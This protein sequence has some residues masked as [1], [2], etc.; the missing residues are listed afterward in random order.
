MLTWLKSSSSEQALV[1][2]TR[3]CTRRMLLSFD[4]LRPSFFASTVSLVF[5][6][7]LSALIFGNRAFYVFR[8]ISASFLLSAC[9]GGESR[10]RWATRGDEL[11]LVISALISPF[12]SVDL[13]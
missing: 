11:G 8:F 6:S 13:F 1:F 5:G 4:L 2:V 7:R 9:S 3:I 12:S 10:R